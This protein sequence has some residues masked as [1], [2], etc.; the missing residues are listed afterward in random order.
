MSATEASFTARTLTYKKTAYN[1]VFQRTH[2]PARSQ[3][4]P[5]GGGAYSGGGEWTLKGIYTPAGS[6][7]FSNSGLPDHHSPTL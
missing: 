6:L 4:F 7:T 3:D 2:I 1:H 5:R